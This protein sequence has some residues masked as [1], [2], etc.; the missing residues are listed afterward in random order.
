MVE[1]LWLT[2]PPTR[3]RQARRTSVSARCVEA[4]ADLFSPAPPLSSLLLPSPPPAH[5]LH[6]LLLSFLLALLS[7]LLICSPL[8]S[9]HLISSAP[10]STN[11][12]S[13]HFS[14]HLISSAPLSTN[15]PSSPLLLSHPLISPHL[16]SSHLSSSAPLSSHLI[17]SAPLSTNLISTPLQVDVQPI[18]D[19]QWCR[20]VPSTGAQP[21]RRQCRRI[22]QNGTISSVPPASC[23]RGPARLGG[24]H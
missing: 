2:T 9:S 18:D 14:S 1:C 3:A 7:S 21:T 10:F 8:F 22:R 15:L 6:S 13:S 20:C 24:S 12:P 11:L 5:L 4:H 23:P 17:S 19:S 16:I